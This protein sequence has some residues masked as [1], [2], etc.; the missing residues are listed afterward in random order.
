MAETDNANLVQHIR[1]LKNYLVEHWAAQ[2]A[3][4]RQMRQLRAMLHEINVPDEYKPTVQIFRSPILPDMIH[5]VVATLTVN[6]PS[7]R[8]NLMGD[9]VSDEHNSTLIEQWLAGAHQ[10]MEVQAKRRVF[11]SLID[12]AVADGIGVCQ[13]QWQPQAWSPF[14]RRNRDERGEYAE[15]A[16]PY[17][18]RLKRHVQTAPFP[19]AWRDIDPLTYYYWDSY[20]NEREVI[21][22]EEVP[23]APAARSLGVQR[24][25]GDKRWERMTPGQPFP[26]NNVPSGQTTELVHLWTDNQAV[27]LLDG[28]HART[29]NHK[30]GRRCIFD[31]AGLSTHERAPERAYLPVAFAFSQLIPFLD[32]LL[33]MKANWMYLNAFPRTYIK[34]RN[35]RMT[36]IH[37][38]HEALAQDAAQQ[39]RVVDITTDLAKLSALITLY[40]DEEVGYLIP[41]NAGA[42]LDE[43]VQ[44]A[45][46]MIQQA[47]IGDVVRGNL[48]SDASGYLANQLMTAARLAYDPITDNGKFMLRDGAEFLLYGV[49]KLAQTSVPVYGNSV[50]SGANKRA[51]LELSDR[52]IDGIYETVPTL[53]PLL[54]SNFI[55]EGRFW[56]EQQGAG[57]VSRRTYQEK[58]L[59]LESP[60]EEDYRILLEKAKAQVEER[61]IQEAGEKAGI[62]P[63]PQPAASSMVD[64]FGQ[65]MPGQQP[66]GGLDLGSVGLPLTPGQGMPLTAEQTAPGGMP[67]LPGGGMP[68]PGPGQNPGG[69]FPQPMETNIGGM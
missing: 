33:T 59:H 29:I 11:R 19:F 31:F 1:E 65:P 69:F 7:W 57:G 52:E 28:E 32:R 21:L 37:Q 53:D 48:G 68:G 15:D 8:R 27:Y 64:Q 60:E 66:P 9:R 20:N 40:Q 22:V 46:G 24:N 36:T 2:K 12:S 54:P 13:Y 35:E 61:M 6:Y 58:G 18:N 51:L 30:F 41:P 50:E 14:P 5:R 23:L 63:K 45:M 62:L 49:D 47:G 26:E 43:M 39:T 34:L 25:A 67:A 16:D 17:L 44:I 55:M 4:I 38:V 56:L 3:M 42:G 10:R